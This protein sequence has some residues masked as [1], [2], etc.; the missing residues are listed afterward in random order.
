MRK[1][2]KGFG[3]D[4]QIEGHLEEGQRV[5]LVEDLA[6]DGASKVTFAQALRTAGAR[7]ADAFVVFFYGAFPGAIETLGAAGLTLHYL[8][9]W[10]DVVAEAEAAGHLGP[11]SVTAVR[12]FL[13][14]PKTWS[15]AHG[16][17][18]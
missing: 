5:L 2:P 16:G 6:T 8:A 9:T 3:R 17:R 1:K 18:G 4:A 12:A 11:A 13:D 10:R 15:S 14:D 7:V